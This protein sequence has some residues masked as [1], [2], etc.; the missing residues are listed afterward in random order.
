MR[1]RTRVMQRNVRMV[2]ILVDGKSTVADLSLKTGNS[3]LT[4][5]A[6]RELEKGG[7]VEPL[8]EQDSLW[9]EGKK[10]AQEIRDAAID[11]AIQF[12]SPKVKVDLTNHESSMPED[13]LSK[14]YIAP[15]TPQIDSSISQFSIAPMQSERSAVA[16]FTQDNTEKLSK[17]QFRSAEKLNLPLFGRIKTFF[18]TN[19]QKAEE[20]IE[21]KPINRRSQR[22]SMGWPVILMLGI[23]GSLFLGLLT[24]FLFPYDSYLSEVEAA[25]AQA[26]GRPVKVGHLKVNLYPDLG[27]VLSDVRM[28]TGAEE[29]HVAEVRI[30][31]AISTLMAS[32]KSFR[33]VVLSGVM[34]PAE[35]IV[36]F[37]LTA[38]P[39]IKADIEH[40][41]FEKM[42][43]S[44]GGLAVS[45]MEGEVSLSADGLFQALLLH[46]SDRSLSIEAKPLP[47]G[48][49]VSLEGFGWRSSQASP[50][51]FDS[52]SLK[53]HLDSKAFTISNMELRIFDGLIKG[54]T[55]LHA[56]KKPSIS[57]EVSFE[58]VA[59]TR[60]GNALG[61]GQQFNG[62]TAGK[63]R[64]SANADSWR[65]IFSAIN[66]DGEFVIHRGSIRGID[67]TEAVRRISS[68]PVQGGETSFEQLTGKIKLSPMSYQFSGLVMNSG[69]MQSTGYFVINNDLKVNGRMELQMRGTANRMRV[70]ITISGTL[71]TPNVQARR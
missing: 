19:G 49:D 6:L 5:N 31:P 26:S 10:V 39:T 63:M 29:I 61:L 48:L 16:M 28:G 41:S 54:S 33:K 30:Q 2:L 32:R 22:N 47:Q 50:F 66:A 44:F 67:L 43:I 11:K 23:V 38:K 18:Q 35:L 1:K 45:E 46:S 15:D 40:L 71:Q 21:I 36:G 64:F 27:F 3:Q 52:L 20:N 14:H 68:V 59:T 17:K 65:E 37:A 7:L 8:V 56:D 13:L 58:R 9:A 53:G 57:G 70:P 51:L 34:F 55:V 42:N 12:S 62:E 69:L 4:E 25:F 60:L 24:V